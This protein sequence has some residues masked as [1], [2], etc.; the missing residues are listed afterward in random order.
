[1]RIWFFQNTVGVVNGSCIRPNFHETVRRLANTYQIL[2]VVLFLDRL[3]V[4]VNFRGEGSFTRAPNLC[5]VSGVRR[6]RRVFAAICAAAEMEWTKKAAEIGQI[7]H[8]RFQVNE[9]VADYEKISGMIL[10]LYLS[11]K[12]FSII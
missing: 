5:H 6:E 4:T 7:S 2:T 11:L 10:S 9:F 8:V 1:M 3:C 12:P